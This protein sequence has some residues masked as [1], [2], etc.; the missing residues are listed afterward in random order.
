VG[1]SPALKGVCS[2]PGD[3]LGVAVEVSGSNA[4]VMGAGFDGLHGIDIV[5]PVVGAQL[6]S[7]LILAR[8]KSCGRW[9]PT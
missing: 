5:L 2:V 1:R 8:P 4:V 7:A 6:K 3:A 9:V